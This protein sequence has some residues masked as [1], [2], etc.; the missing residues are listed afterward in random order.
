MGVLD[1]VRA[2]SEDRG[3]AECK[4][5]V[6]ELEEAALAERRCQAGCK[7]LFCLRR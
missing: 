3:V 7:G 6:E 2:T 5:K 1:M 4:C